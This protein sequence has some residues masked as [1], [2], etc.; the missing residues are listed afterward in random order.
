MSDEPAN[1]AIVVAP[2]EKLKGDSSFVNDS[3]PL[4]DGYLKMAQVEDERTTEDW[5]AVS[6][7]HLIVSG[8]FAAV[9]ATFLSPS[10][11][12]LKPDPQEKSAFYLEKTYQL[13]AES[14]RTH[15]V[16]FF[17]SQSNPPAFSPPKSAVWVNS[18]WSLSLVIILSSALLAVL[19]Q[20]WAR[21]YIKLTQL[22]SASSPHG[23]ARVRAFFNKGVEDLRLQWAVDALPI[24]LHTSLVLFLAGFIIFSFGYNYTVFEVVVPWVGLCAVIY[25]CFTLLPLFRHDSPYYTPLSPI[26][27]FIYN[28][29]QHVAFRILQWC[30]SFHFFSE[31]TWNRF[32]HSENHYRRR[33]LHRMEDAAEQSAQKSPSEVDG[34]ILLWVLQSSDESIPDFRDSKV[35]DEFRAAFKMSNAEKMADTLI[36]LMNR[37]LSSDLITQ[38]TKEGRIKNYTEAMV[39]LSLPI[40]RRTL[41]RVLY[42][43]WGALLDSVEFGLLLRNAHYKNPFAEYYSQCVVSAIIAR[44]KVRDDRWFELAT[45]QLGISRST[46]DSYLSH[47]DS[48]LLANCIFLCRRT[49][50]VY[51][52]HEWNYDV[53]SRSKTLDLVSRFNTQDALPGLQHE[54]CDMWNKLVRNAGDRRSQNPSIYILKHIRNVYFKLHRSIAAPTAFTAETPD[55]DIILLFSSSYPPCKMTRHHPMP[56]SAMEYDVGVKR[57]EEPLPDDTSP[58]LPMPAHARATSSNN[59][60]WRFRLPSNPFSVIWGAIRTYATLLCPSVTP[61]STYTAPSP[62][63]DQLSRI[64]HHRKKVASNTPDA[65]P[66]VVRTSSN[67]GHTSIFSTDARSVDDVFAV[68]QP[69]AIPIAPPPSAVL[70]KDGPRLSGPL[71]DIIHGTTLTSASSTAGSI[72]DAPGAVSA[73]PHS[74]TATPSYSG[75]VSSR[76]SADLR[77]VPPHAHIPPIVLN[78]LC[79][80]IRPHSFGVEIT[81]SKQ[82]YYGSSATPA[83]GAQSPLQLQI[84]RNLFVILGHLLKTWMDQGDLA[85]LRIDCYSWNL[86][87]VPAPRPGHRP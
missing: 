66:G 5:N 71:A 44:V 16:P 69:S 81:R 80:L 26:L 1:R 65:T 84:S 53:Y 40:N 54:F 29:T 82:L 30:T 72:P 46:L 78:P 12:N 8:L 24:L 67:A 19:V 10:F 56:C 79:V 64:R 39:G 50:D 21:R 61:H 48:V 63:Q 77:I 20:Q 11:Q 47:G 57:S 70:R 13:F 86:Y 74:H 17:P 68:S 52:E 75:S 22:Q 60:S 62:S 15:D 27:W 42:K 28:G 2:E 6:R 38:S 36:G 9:V 37:T 49:L 55:D 25:V 18:L 35:L 23:R 7:N 76:D 73:L 34:R 51:S 3:E 87:G 4:F 14:N 31:E 45:G 58:V 43:D 41:S 83:V 33:F 32:G 59:G 85:H